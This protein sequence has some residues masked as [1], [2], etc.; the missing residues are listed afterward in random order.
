MD[1]LFDGALSLEDALY[2][3][4]YDQGVADGARAG[5][6]EGRSVGMGKGFEKFSEAGKL[7][8][9]A[10]VW[11]NRLPSAKRGLSVE[12]AGGEAGGGRTGEARRSP[13]PATSGEGGQGS[14]PPLPGNTRLARN[15]E[16]VH[17]LME[18][19]T[20]STEN[21]DEAVQ[22]FDDRFKRAQG[23]AKVVERMIGGKVSKVEGSGS[24][25][26]ES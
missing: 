25:G 4:G 17:A 9:R 23:K 22:D 15:V 21:S 10:V 6:L 5:K 3:R 7:Y 19:A 24:K 2:K 16:T 13:E 1:D 14:L 20:L 12:E 18:P 11:A 8:G 26:E